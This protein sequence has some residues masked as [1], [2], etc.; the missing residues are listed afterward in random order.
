MSEHPFGELAET[1][2]VIAQLAADLLELFEGA[3]AIAGERVC[4]VGGERL[5]DQRLGALSAIG[6][7][8]VDLVGGERTLDLRADAF[9]C[10]QLRHG[11]DTSSS[12]R[13]A[14]I[15]A[16]G[17]VTGR[18]VLRSRGTGWLGSSSC[19]SRPRSARAYRPRGRAS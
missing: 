11:N 3:V 19:S 17:T 14:D 18:R 16:A 13:A 12:S 1:E 10:G 4:L 5:L 2:Q 6:R 9:G 15:E 7:G 8:E